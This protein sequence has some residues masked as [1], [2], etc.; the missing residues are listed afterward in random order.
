MNHEKDRELAAAFS[1]L[2]REEQEQLPPFADVVRRGRARTLRRVTPRRLRL[3]WAA[4]AMIAIA[5]LALWLGLRRPVPQTPAGIPSLAEWRSPTDFL[6]ET[7]GQ[8]IL[9]APAGWSRSVL[10]LE[11]H[12]QPP[13]RRDPS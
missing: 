2:R 9:A 12:P 1:A 3:V 13:E 8:E 5:G 7:S 11:T 4:A 10:D 6:L